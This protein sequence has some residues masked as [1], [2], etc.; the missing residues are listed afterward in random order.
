VTGN[1]C[2]HLADT[3]SRPH[4][5]WLDLSKPFI[6]AYKAR[7]TSVDNFIADEQI[8]YWYRRT[9]RSLNCD[10][11]DTTAGR[12]AN[13]DSGNYF[14]G[15]PDGWQTMEDVVY[16]VALLKEAGQV[17]VRS[18][19]NTR[20]QSVP[21]GAS[22]FTVP[23]GVGEQNFQLTRGSSTVLQGR[24]LMDISDTCPCGLYNF[25]A[26]VGT[27]PHGPADALQAEGLASLTLGLRVTTCQPRPSLGTPPPVVSSSTSTRVTSSTS[28]SAPPVNT[29]TCIKGTVADGESG[30]LIGL[31]DFS[32]HF[33]Y[34]PPGP[35]K[36]L[37]KG[38]PVTPPPETG[39]NG[40][41]VPGL[42]DSYRGLCSFACNH[43]YCPSTAC[44]SN[45]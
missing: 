31:C 44:T 24:S 12:P 40:C 29:G 6:A 1:V 30:N 25:N 9:L 11:T 14:M 27:L 5:G 42:G 17:T 41:P 20:T 7:E 3:A 23:A 28:S 43:G 2:K 8:V 22:I 18:G 10:G 32:C 36:C 16:V 35:C 45:C 26:Y 13:N 33:G 37:E 19:G 15:R 39:I 4:L 38:T 21:K 34:C